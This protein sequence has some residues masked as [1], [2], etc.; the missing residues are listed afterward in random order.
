MLR[1]S[2]LFSPIAALLKAKEPAEPLAVTNVT[3]I[4]A[5]GAPERPETT[6]VLRS[7]RIVSVGNAPAPRGM[8]IVEGR[9]KYLIPGLWDAHVHALWDNE[10]PNVFFPLFLANGVTS[11]REMGGP[12]PA[13]EQ[14]R[15]R[16]R[17]ARREV[18]GPDLI[19][20]GPFVDGPQPIWPGSIR[21]GNEAEARRAVDDLQRAGVQFVKV[22]SQVPRAAY[23]ALADE[24][25]KK[26]IPF[27]GH[28]P[29]FIDVTEASKA[30]QRS[31]EH[32]MGVLLGT[33]SRGAEL[34][35]QLLAGANVNQLNGALVDT[36]DAGR[37]AALC[38]L[39]VR[40]GTWQVPTLTI[41]HARPYLA[42]LA[43]AN[44]PRLRYLPA[45]ITAGWISRD[46]PRQPGTAAA[47]ES[48]KRLY[49]KEVELVGA[50]NRA[51]VRI[52]AGTDT[53]NPF[54]FPGFSLHDE[55]ALL[56]E[57][58]L[59]PLAALQAATR[60]PAEMTGCAAE[61]GTIEKNKRAN[62]VLLDANPLADIRNTQKIAAVILQGRLLTRND[63]DGMLADALRASGGSFRPPA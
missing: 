3:V 26:H 60:N 63:L 35:S 27:A 9:G 41:R 39:F 45:P 56:V 1:R 51:G 34:T 20:P 59:S 31:I 14:V 42:E 57:A 47:I 49:R 43:A 12:L 24:A 23:F 21:V 61:L 18:L 52:A 25:R 28:V 10:R 22:Y 29:P 40:N 15:W 48:R 58:G 13:A 62:L 7:G 44:D 19:V 37:A 5:T 50:M 46:D 17:V 11:V 32:L 6:V 8:A 33:S 36:Y 55:L 2:L 53:P 4:D 38:D 16:E 30:G 54:C